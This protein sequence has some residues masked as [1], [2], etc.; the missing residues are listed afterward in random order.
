MHFA[1][2]SSVPTLRVT[3]SRSSDRISI[4]AET[5]WMPR[6]QADT[7]EEI[8]T[9]DAPNRR[10]GIGVLYSSGG[11]QATEEVATGEGPLERG[12]SG[13]GEP[14]IASAGFTNGVTKAQD[15]IGDEKTN[16][17]LDLS[18]ANDYRPTT[19]AITFL[20]DIP[21]GS[22]VELCVTGGRYQERDIY[23]GAKTR[24]W[25]FRSS[26]SLKAAWDGSTLLSA[27][28]HHSAKADSEGLD[29]TEI[30]PF[31]VSRPRA[32]ST[33]LL[34][35][36]I[37]NR[38][39][40]S[41]PNHFL[42]Q[43]N[44]EVTVDGGRGRILAYP[45]PPRTV[46][47]DEEESIDLLYR[48][49]P[50]FAIGHGCAAGWDT[51]GE[52]GEC[53]RV[54]GESLPAVETPSITPQVI[55][56]DGTEVR[57]PMAPLAGL[58]PSQDGMAS[59]AEVVALYREWI[60]EREAAVAGLDERHQSAAVRH[61]NDCK[62]LADRMHEGLELLR[63]DGLIAD[64]FRLANHAVLLQQIHSAGGTRQLIYDERPGRLPGPEALARRGAGRP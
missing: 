1:E 32:G 7:G 18:G 49:V 39:A 64:A 34:T 37:I 54:R 23:V 12:S 5:A 24:S 26:C 19:M 41:T 21:A 43:V 52:T 16:H 11:R 51:D 15:D 53:L 55:R 6:R 3:R 56:G 9:R 4:D 35:V 44:F 33:S 8:L 25:W 50:T 31:A 47:D 63:S 40:G 58:I 46:R 62:V 57:V 13:D 45:E 28:R 14:T 22:R 59:L 60:S 36:G 42:F 27:S 17:D 2:N 20:A 30:E 61:L 38:T 48:D 29:G 10:Y